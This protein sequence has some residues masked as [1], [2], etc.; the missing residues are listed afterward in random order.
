MNGKH[1]SGAW[2]CTLPINIALGA[3]VY[4]LLDAHNR[5]C[6]VGVTKGLRPRLA[7]HAK[8]KPFTWWIAYSVSG[9]HFAV[10]RR[11]IEAT[12]P[13]LGNDGQERWH[14]SGSLVVDRDAV[15]RGE[16]DL[17]AAVA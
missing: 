10:E 8:N 14:P 12:Q 11:M 15:L 16:C 9:E 5:I 7:R 13:Y 2:P 1:L 3:Y 6:Y 4:V 17:L